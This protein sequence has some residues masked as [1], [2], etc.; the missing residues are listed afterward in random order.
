M[1]RDDDEHLDYWL[2]TLEKMSVMD[3]YFARDEMAILKQ[4]NLDQVQ[5][6]EAELKQLIVKIRSC[7]EQA[8][9]PEDQIVQE[10]AQQWVSALN[11][12]LPDPGM[13]RKFVVMHQSE[14]ALHSLSGVD[15]VLENYLQQAWVARRYNLYRAF[16]SEAE[17]VNFKQH[18]MQYNSEWM[19]IFS[20]LREL[21]RQGQPAEGA[22][23]QRVIQR[24]RELSMLMW[25]H[26][27]ELVQ[28]ARQAHLQEPRLNQGG[29]LTP[30]LLNFAR[31]GMRFLEQQMAQQASD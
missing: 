8:L 23:V 28:R 2:M 12:A 29:G 21:K 11:Q 26:Q 22:A 4:K 25:N 7:Y 24:W 10:L 5:R 14:E 17:L 6:D 15:A 16:F 20:D 18:A 3:N 1:A 13:L 27:P 30:D 19:Q 9:A 31:Q